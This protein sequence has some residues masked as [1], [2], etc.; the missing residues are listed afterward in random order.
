[1]AFREALERGRTVI[2]DGGD[3][4]PAFAQPLPVL[5]QLDQLTLAEWS[6]VGRAIENQHR[7][8]RAANGF[9][10]LRLA[11]LVRQHER[12]DECASGDTRFGSAGL[13]DHSTQGYRE[14]SNTPAE[15]QPSGAPLTDCHC[16]RPRNKRN[17][18][19]SV[20]SAGQEP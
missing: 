6:P 17:T 3:T 9:E 7:P 1:M 13:S 4:Q 11:V 15:T 16:I 5:I 14:D 12:R 10:G 20:R 18:L 2:T 8:I 19:G